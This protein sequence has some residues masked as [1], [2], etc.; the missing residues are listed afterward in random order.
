MGFLLHYSSC[1]RSVLQT[2]LQAHPWPKSVYIPNRTARWKVGE[3]A[4]EITSDIARCFCSHPILPK[5]VTCLSLSH[6]SHT[7]SSSLRKRFPLKHF[8]SLRHSHANSFSQWNKQTN[9]KNSASLTTYPFLSAGQCEIWSSCSKAMSR[10]KLCK[11]P[12]LWTT[13]YV[14]TQWKSRTIRAGLL[15]HLLTA[16]VNC[17]NQSGADGIL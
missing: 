10:N 2:R 4:K 7:S 3:E 9:K 15:K 13:A 16:R 8:Y 14:K 17:R 6:F 11:E 1:S 5:L 12:L